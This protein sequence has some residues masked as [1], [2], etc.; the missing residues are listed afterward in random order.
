MSFILNNLFGRVFVPG[1]S[2]TGMSL[3]RGAR[4]LAVV[5]QQPQGRVGG[6]M[7]RLNSVLRQPKLKLLCDADILK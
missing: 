5:L 3:P 7:Q 4:C 6:G 1:L 2:A